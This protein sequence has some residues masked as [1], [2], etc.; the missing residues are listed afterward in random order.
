MVTGVWAVGGHHNGR[1]SG[2][3]QVDRRPARLAPP[4]QSGI[5]LVSLSEEVEFDYGLEKGKLAVNLSEKN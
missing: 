5:L 1:V 2:E 4:R 3:V